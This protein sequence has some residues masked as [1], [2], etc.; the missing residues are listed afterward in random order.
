MSDIMRITYR[1]TCEECGYEIEDEMCYEVGDV[2]ICESCKREAEA[3]IKLDVLR[4]IFEDDM[5]ERKII[6][7]V[8]MTDVVA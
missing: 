7:P 3:Q 6:T 2:Y 4:A 5:D 8:K 1:P